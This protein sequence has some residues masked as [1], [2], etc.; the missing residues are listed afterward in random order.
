METIVAWYAVLVGI[1]VLGLWAVSLATGRV[2][3][4]VARPWEIRAHLAAEGLMAI[5]M[6]AGGLA[7]LSG[8]TDGPRLLLVGLGSTLYSVVA[9]SGYY[10][11][12]REWPPVVMFA[13]LFVLT[14]L[15][16]TALITQAA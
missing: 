4:L 16:A 1:L 12:R 10:L 5:L 7:T 8:A 6:L 2:P 15:A 14:L 13:V 9:S 3:E 11:Q